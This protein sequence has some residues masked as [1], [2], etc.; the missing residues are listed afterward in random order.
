MERMSTLDAGFFF[1]EHACV[2]MH[3]GAVAVF[4]S[5]A[6]S[7]QDIV[8]LYA[9]KLSRVPRYRQVVR[10]GPLTMFRPAWTDDEHFEIGYHVRRA[11]IPQPGRVSQLHRTAGEIYAQP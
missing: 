2:P 4:E 5:P 11:A 1:A 3:L 9:A 8:G 6:P 7:L 10:T